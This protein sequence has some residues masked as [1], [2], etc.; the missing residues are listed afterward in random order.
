MR[1]LWFDFTLTEADSYLYNDEYENFNCIV[2]IDRNLK[3]VIKPDFV[4]TDS[5]VGFFFDDPDYFD[6][7]YY[8]IFALSIG[9][10][11]ISSTWG[12]I[13]LLESTIIGWEL[14]SE[15]DNTNEFVPK[16]YSPNQN[17]PNPFNSSTKIKFALSKPEFV[18]IEV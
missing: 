4:N 2:K 13:S 1:F 15:I 17:Y 14:I 6:D 8:Y 5:C 9:P 10:I 3:L 11:I 7:E 16:R 18:K 12:G